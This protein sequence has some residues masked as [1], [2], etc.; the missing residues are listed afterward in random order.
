MDL[1]ALIDERR[2]QSECI[3]RIRE[4]PAIPPQIRDAAVQAIDEHLAAS[5]RVLAEMLAGFVAG[6]AAGLHAVDIEV[7]A[8][9]LSRTARTIQSCRLL[10][11]GRA[12]EIPADIG[13]RFIACILADDSVPAV[14]A[15]KRFYIIEET[16]SDML[17]PGRLDRCSL[18]ILE[19]LYPVSCYHLRIRLPA[20]VLL[21]RQIDF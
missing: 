17:L 10:V 8:T 12:E 13:E 19:E 16:R 9:I 5:R 2:A 15:V 14:E 18:H 20:T 1:R 3:V 6:A 21:D 11:E 4:E 7:S